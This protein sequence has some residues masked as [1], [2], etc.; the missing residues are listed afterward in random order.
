LI[1]A[2]P[3]P[4]PMTT[5]TLR[6]LAVICGATL[7][8][9]GDKVVTGP[10]SLAE[11]GPTEVSFLANPR[12]AQQITDTAAAAVI[13]GA[14]YEG[15]VADLDILRCEDPN[16][17]F[18]E[19]VKA[20][21]EAECSVAQGIDESAIVDPSAEVHPDACVGALVYIGPRA[22]VGSAAVLHPNVTIEEGVT[23]GEET[24]LQAGV[25][26]LPRVMV[27]ARCALGAG[28][29]IGSEGFGFDPANGGWV[30]VPQCGTVVVEDDVETGAN[31]TID[32]ARFGAT[33]IGRGAKLD[34]QVHVGHNCIVEQNAMLIAQVALGGSCRIE[35][36]AILAGRV[37]VTGHKTVGAG[38]RVGGGSVVWNDLEPGGEF[39]G[40]PARPKS[41]FMKTM[42]LSR[43]LPKLIERVRLL[44]TKLQELERRGETS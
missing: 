3:L 41:E 18:T 12:Y 1:L 6:E 14:D 15:S 19:V 10:A 4:E 26:L 36:G 44:E 8:G 13:V 20:F 31:V 29:V 43:R 7:D 9:D 27:G 38:A 28:T 25:H 30:K 42:A 5:K 33:R 40:F 22:R 24:V 11:A 2:G 37:G 21:S 39:L 16:R 32:R 23:V 34:N 35:E 17:A